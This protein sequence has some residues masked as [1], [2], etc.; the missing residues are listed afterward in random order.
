MLTEHE[1]SFITSG[2]RGGDNIMIFLVSLSVGK[3]TQTGTLANS[4]NPD[5]RP[6]HLIRVCTVC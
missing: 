1:K 6:K 4:E 5:K 3:S 2:A